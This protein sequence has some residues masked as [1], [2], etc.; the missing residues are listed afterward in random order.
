MTKLI[1]QGLWFPPILMAPAL[2]AL[3]HAAAA[4][5]SV[6]ARMLRR[7]RSPSENDSPL[8]L[9]W[10]S[11]L[12]SNGTESLRSLSSAQPGPCTWCAGCVY[13]RSWR[14]RT[15]PSRRTRGSRR[16]LCT[17]TRSQVILYMYE[18]QTT[19]FGSSTCNEC[20]PEASRC[21]REWARI[22]RRWTAWGAGCVSASF[23]GVF[24][25][26]YPIR[27]LAY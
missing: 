22:G 5:V 24:P 26:S 13:G 12:K 25:V 3:P 17:Q 11:S 9:C 19:T 20:A 6:S 8:N 4:D 2:G 1:E 27:I 21:G 14:P 23:W 18:Q 10:R 16:P 7:G 15:A